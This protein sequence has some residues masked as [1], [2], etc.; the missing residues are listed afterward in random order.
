MG[1]CAC[2]PRAELTFRRPLEGR[3]G[4]MD[5]GRSVITSAILD[6]IFSVHHL[7]VFFSSAS[8]RLYM[9]GYCR[10]VRLQAPT[11]YLPPPEDRGGVSTALHGTRRPRGLAGWHTGAGMA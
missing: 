6:G 7:C 5:R 11:T 10:Q 1:F 4:S 3:Y 8:R 2:M 9:A